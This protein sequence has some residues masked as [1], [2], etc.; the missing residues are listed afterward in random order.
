MREYVLTILAAAAVTYLLTPLVRRFA[1]A[2]GA[3]HAARDRDVH[4]VPTP[5]LGGFAMYAGL[6]A[7]LVVA[8][9]LPALNSAFAETN[10]AKGLLLAGGVVVIMGFVDDRWGM[11]AISKLA[12]QVAAG[13]ILVWSGASVTWLPEPGGNALLLTSGQQM[14]LTILVVVVTINAVNFID[15]LDGLAAGIVGIGAA[16]F[17]I[18]YY[19]LIHRLGLPDQTGPALA[20]A[21]LVGVCLGFLPHN[22]YPARIFMGDTG[23]ML[24]GLLLAY[25]PISSIASSDPSSLTNY[26]SGGTV[27]RFG[28]FLPLLLPAAIMLIPYADLLMA[29]IRRTRAGLSVFAPDKKHLHHRMLAI[30]HSHRTSVLI[31]YLWAALFAGSVVWLS[32]VRTPLFVLAFVTVGAMLALLLVSMPRLRPWARSGSAPVPGRQPAHGPAKQAAHGPARAATPDRARVAPARS[33]VPAGY[34]PRAVQPEPGSSP[35]EPA[36][37]T[38]VAFYPAPPAEAGSAPP[39]GPLAAG[40]ATARSSGKRRRSAPPWAP[41]PPAPAT[42]APPWPPA[43]PPSWPPAPPPPWPPPQG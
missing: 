43:P 1:I 14:G 12:G 6:A 5:L 3:K 4:V 42:G 27:N 36:P 16:A 13:V 7:G 19:T 41:A 22:F 24:I 35:W 15:G 9:R 21:V 2:I 34:P 39:D 37:P 17:F 8:S 32:I 10:M 33:A 30:G 20:S 40:P 18:Y 25:A 29:V 11:G 38:E 31:M 26:A 23:A 28:A